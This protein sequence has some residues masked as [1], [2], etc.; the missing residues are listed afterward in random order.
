MR[1]PAVVLLLVAGLVAAADK[2]NVVFIL[3][4]DLGYGDVQSL[5]PGRGKIATPHL[6]QL[7][8]E[9]MTFTA[10][11]S[12][13][14]VCTPTR[15]G[16][17]TG[18]FAWRTRLQNG[19]LMGFSPP[20]IATNRLTVPAL[21]QQHGYRTACIGKWHLGMD[22]SGD[23]RKRDLTRQIGNGPLTRGFDEYFGI[24]AS[25][26]MPPFAYIEGDRFTETPSV[27][28][29]WLRKGP[30]APGFDAADV[31]PAL[32][33]RAETFIAAQAAAR[34]PFFL[35]LP[36]T[37]P[38]TPILPTA[39]WQ[40]RS[41]LGAYGD[42]VMQTDAAVG[43]VRAAL[44]RAGAASNTLFFFTSDN[45][46][47]PAADTS[48][49]ERQG[50]FASA[51]RR[52]YKADIFDGGHRVPFLAC[53]PGRVA[54]GRTNAQLICLTDLMATCAEL[55][56]ATLPAD[57]GEDSFSF[58]P[59]LLGAA[60]PPARASVIHHSINGSFALRRG[61][62]KLALCPDSGGWSEPRPGGKAARALPPQQL[63]NLAE[64][65][66]EQRNLAGEQPGL[67]A[68]LT[69]L[70]E[71]HVTEGR[72]TPGPTQN[73]DVPVRVSRTKE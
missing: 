1:L 16:I 5:N 23:D 58:L 41:G 27:E 2:P 46:C 34:R 67:V 6:D 38:H 64:D 39:E 45:G 9:G 50:H 66:A 43:T 15:Y 52:G 73:N 65:A 71:R 12:G 13:S 53:W 42:F 60:P 21:L 54:A 62:W 35:Y 59:A 63:Y 37:S 8:R 33:R 11:H 29:E 30:A 40:G 19:V 24:A 28:K 47:S 18:R 17:L 25:L 48:G 31:L 22:F 7:V 56:G 68:E 36:L 72:S 57:A 10:A 4:D 3:A 55:V 26:D 51:D 69:A 20:L 44:E 32:V 61:P 14:A 49:L 70:L